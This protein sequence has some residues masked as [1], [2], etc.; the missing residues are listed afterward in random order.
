MPFDGDTYKREL[1]CA[2]LTGQL[3]R[4]REALSRWERWW[5]L[6]ELQAVAGGSEA[7]ISARVRDLRKPKFGNFIIEHKRCEDGLW[8]Y[9]MIKP[10]EW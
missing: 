1:D 2:R 7:G 8:R 5:T 6:S 4:V 3:N 10:E 9:M